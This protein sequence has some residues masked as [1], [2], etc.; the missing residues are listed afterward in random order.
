VCYA[1]L[2]LQRGA[3]LPERDHQSF[4]TPKKDRALSLLHYS[5]FA[6][7]NMPSSAQT[8][9]IPLEL[10]GR[11]ID[12]VADW[13]FLQTRQEQGQFYPKVS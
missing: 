5:L 10:F 7:L 8:I 1:K 2:T 13:E 6:E 11:I 9:E 12:N 4:S 3:E